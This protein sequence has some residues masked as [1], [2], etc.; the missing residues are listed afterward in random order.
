MKSIVQYAE[1]E[2]TQIER[3]TWTLM[4]KS[5]SVLRYFGSY[6]EYHNMSLKKITGTT[7]LPLL[8]G[9]EFLGEKKTDSM[10]AV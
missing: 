2:N 3:T 8:G 4:C 5:L 9:G 10:S 7:R 6:L 1:E